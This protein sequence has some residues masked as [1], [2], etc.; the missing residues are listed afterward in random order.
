MAALVASILAYPK[1]YLQDGL[2]T[3]LTFVATI[4]IAAR[5]LALSITYVAFGAFWR[6]AGA[7]IGTAIV[8]S[9]FSVHDH[10]FILWLALGEAIGAALSARAAG[11]PLS[12]F[13]AAARAVARLYG[14]DH[15]KSLRWPQAWFAKQVFI[16]AKASGE[17]RRIVGAALLLAQGLW[18]SERH[19]EMPEQLEPIIDFYQQSQDAIS[20][21]ELCV[22]T[23]PGY[24]YTGQQTRGIRRLRLAYFS[25]NRELRRRRH[26]LSDN[27]KHAPLGMPIPRI[28]SI[29]F[30]LRASAAS[31][32]N[33]LMAL[34]H[35]T[36]SLHKALAWGRRS[37]EHVRFIRRATAEMPVPVFVFSDE[38]QWALPA[39][40]LAD[41]LLD[42]GANPNNTLEMVGNLK[43]YLATGRYRNEQDLYQLPLVI[44]KCQLRNGE[45]CAAALQDGLRYGAQRYR[46]ELNLPLSTEFLFVLAVIRLREKD[47]E[48]C[49]ALLETINDHDDEY[50]RNALA[51]SSDDTK[52]ELIARVRRHVDAYFSL[53]FVQAIN[54]HETSLAAYELCM[55]RKGLATQV[56]II[57]RDI[58]MSSKYPELRAKFSRHAEICRA[59]AL[60]IATGN[61]RDLVSLGA[62]RRALEAA[63]TIA[64]P[65][66]RYDDLL[67]SN[68]I[69][70]M[71]SAIETGTL[72]IEYMRI[73]PF[74]YSAVYPAS[75]WKPDVYIAFVI[76]SAGEVHFRLLGDAK[77]ID[78]LI[79]QHN[80]V[81]TGRDS[82]RRAL[83]FSSDAD[84]PGALVTSDCGLLLTRT[85]IE[86]LLSIANKALRLVIAPDSELSLL[87]FASLP[88]L[89]GRFLI[90]EYEIVYSGCGRD[91]LE[92][93]RQRAANERLP[94][95]L[96]CPDY[97]A[98][99]G[100]MLRTDVSLDG[101]SG[102]VDKTDLH[103]SDRATWMG[104]P[105]L[106]GSRLEGELVAHALAG[107]AWF[108][109]R[110]SEG[111]LKRDC[112]SP[113][114]LHIATHGFYLSHRPVGASALGLDR[115]RAH[116]DPMLRSGLAFAGANTFLRERRIVSDEME[117]GLLTAEDVAGMDLLNTELVFLSACE[118]G[119]G[120]VQIGEGVF[121]LR[122]A[123]IL[124]GARTLI[125]TLWKISDL[126]TAILVAYF[127]EYLLGGATKADALRLA[128]HRLR[129]AS[130][131][132]LRNRWLSAARNQELA[133]GDE[134]K[135]RRLDELA[136]MSDETLPFAH[137]CYWA[138]FI[139]QGEPG[140]LRWQP[141]LTK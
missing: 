85:I 118:T 31:L 134:T 10:H 51:G 56:Q 25:V 26:A 34:N 95:I 131:G 8:A 57:R 84:G 37:I 98:T 23:A 67:F 44:A 68:I 87:S 117:D 123:F 33:A 39:L 38:S 139:L 126:A 107:E 116:K 28:D 47:L 72:L 135:R 13:F 129:T 109:L 82:I 94:L 30:R 127:Y 9:L 63:L 40:N 121:G 18:N 52:L 120:Q 78:N 5:Q 53:L 35:E 48:G 138:G 2:L 137:P 32:A 100:K 110:A 1:L 97:D 88:S 22:K 111:R 103:E 80:A 114:V 43:G 55:K 75:Q 46:A 27:V 105:Q 141:R 81:V 17:S 50:L 136:A 76:I 19:Q 133:G 93:P 45:K 61:A 112:K 106:P 36:G 64:V 69:A 42:S 54:S 70:K 74:D 89:G 62:E 21:A 20:H 113:P 6:A 66:I 11:F 119:L 124:A 16:E 7:A 140:V 96:A 128:Q 79:T 90:D 92:S 132:E 104:F 41:L 60:A 15:V 86:P 73:R 77:E 4:G 99:G 101:F 58:L 130:L 122:R 102:K 83:A 24:S 49:K 71:S 125:M 91:I 115:L 65:G 108:G 29:S 59:L 3:W 12:V 14:A